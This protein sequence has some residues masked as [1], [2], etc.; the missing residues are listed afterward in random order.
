MAAAKKKRRDKSIFESIRK[1][2][3]PPSRKLGEDK[4]VER[5]HP[6]DRKAK[7]KKKIKRTD[8]D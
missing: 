4:P 5:A 8:D 2:V 6:A 3:A 1:P 7:H